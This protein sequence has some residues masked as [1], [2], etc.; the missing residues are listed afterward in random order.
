[1]HTS[2][3]KVSQQR[4]NEF[5]ALTEILLRAL[6]KLGM[7]SGKRTNARANVVLFS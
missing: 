2:E 7:Y 5:R 4:T 3:Q 6:Q 1:M